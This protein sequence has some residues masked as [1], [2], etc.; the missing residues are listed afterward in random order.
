MQRTGKRRWI[1][2]GLGLGVV[3]LGAL[4]VQRGAENAVE[5]RLA[6]LNAELRDFAAR[7]QASRVPWE[8]VVAGNAVLDY[9]VIEWALA[10]R[11]GWDEEPPAHLAQGSVPRGGG[12][13]ALLLRE[14]YRRFHL[15]EEVAPSAEELRALRRHRGLLERA[16]R[17]LRRER[18]DWQTD[19]ADFRPHARPH[20]PAYFAF[21]GLV[22]AEARARPVDALPLGTLLAAVGRD[23]ARCDE[24]LGLLAGAGVQRAGYRLLV[25][26]VASGSASDEALAE[27]L[28]KLEALPPLGLEP[29]ARAERLGQ[30]AIL[31]VG[32]GRWQRTVRPSTAV[33]E[34]ARPLRWPAPLLAWEWNCYREAHRDRLQAALAPAPA[35]AEALSSARAR[36]DARWCY[37]AR[38]ILPD[39][40]HCADS[41]D[42][43]ATDRARALATL[44]AAQRREATPP[45]R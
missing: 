45:A 15:G 4:A 30:E 42:A 1:G 6:T 25:E 35:R 24:L 22:V 32:S 12:E 9:Q 31:A 40:G 39:F 3:F 41:L 5:E 18:C 43:L 29:A 2:C 28:G 23:L 38:R 37:L 14:L 21:A 36:L 20:P 19:P 26:A 44:R 7:P 33:F 27:A 16:R 10:P 13:D 34:G 11:P 17:A 8:P